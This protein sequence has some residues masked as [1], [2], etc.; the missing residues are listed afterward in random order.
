[1]GGDFA[2]GLAGPL[3]TANGVARRVVLQ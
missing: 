1:L 2:R 3:E